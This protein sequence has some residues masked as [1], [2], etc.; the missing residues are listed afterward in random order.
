MTSLPPIKEKYKDQHYNLSATLLAAGVFFTAYG[1]YNTWMRTE[2]LFPGPH[3]Y[4][5]TAIVV[6]WAIGAALVPA[7]DKTYKPVLTKEF[8][9]ALAALRKSPFSR[10]TQ[11][12]AEAVVAVLASRENVRDENRF[13]WS[14]ASEMDDLTRL[15]PFMVGAFNV[16]DR[17]C[18]EIVSRD[19]FSGW[20]Q[21]PVIEH[22]IEGSNW[23][24]SDLPTV[25]ASLPSH[26]KRGLDGPDGLV[27]VL[28]R[29]FQL[30]FEDAG[31]TTISLRDFVQVMMTVTV[32]KKSPDCPENPDFVPNSG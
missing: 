4:A 32:E 15:L 18:D 20:L 29:G 2:R 31:R 7:M 6:L 8:E 12:Q 21:A 14:F 23:S 17:D 10:L 16:M 5:G 27:W 30:H 3:V 25:E 1:V 19:E 11:K 22:Q 26:C 28:R 13:G 24:A 9:K